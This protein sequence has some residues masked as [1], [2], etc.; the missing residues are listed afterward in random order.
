[1]KSRRDD[2]GEAFPAEL[3]GPP[4]ETVFSYLTYTV[5]AP[6]I[7]DARGLADV[8]ERIEKMLAA[9][10]PRITQYFNERAHSDGGDD[11]GGRGRK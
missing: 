2:W 5:P 4:H 8:V 10:V 9:M 11:E 1:M 7:G 6:E 3:A